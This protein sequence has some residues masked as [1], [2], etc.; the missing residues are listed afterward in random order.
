MV[1]VH[2][3]PAVSAILLVFLSNRSFAGQTPAITGWHTSLTPVATAL[4]MPSTGMR[5]QLLE[6]TLDP[7]YLAIAALNALKI[8][9]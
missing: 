3:I 7:L 5:V 9:R 6:T 1:S 8:Q 2:L 4:P